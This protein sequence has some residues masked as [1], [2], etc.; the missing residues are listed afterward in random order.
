[1]SKTY[2]HYGHKTFEPGLFETPSNRR[3]ANKPRG[4]L[5]AS[6]IDAH[7]GWKDWCKAES[8]YSCDN[9]DSFCFQF[10]NGTNIFT[11]NSVEDVNRM[12]LQKDSCNESIIRAIDFESMYQSGIDAIEYNLS[13]DGNLYF[14][15]YGWDCDRILVL[16]PK[17]VIPI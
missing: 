7:Y 11:I 15:L 2:I 17:V 10:T 3:Y 1:M 4:G 14:A 8:Y 16:N 13:N 12:P 5:W 9:E 6:A